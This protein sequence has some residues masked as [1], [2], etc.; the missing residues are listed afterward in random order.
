M[1]DSLPII[2]SLNH[3]SVLVADV[4]RSL[5]F[6][7]G[8]L[9]LQPDPA[10]GARA[11]PGAWL[12]LGNGQQIHLLEL[13]NPDPKNGRPP[14]GGRDRHFA[15]S[16]PDIDAVA[17]RLDAAGVEYTLSASGRRALFCRDPD[18][19]AIEFVEMP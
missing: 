18:A 12:L 1:T 15:V 11:F 13:P 16:T 17:A 5:S 2:S 3:A 7:Q 6:Y 8:V 4:V 10:R 14:H 9:G 19:N